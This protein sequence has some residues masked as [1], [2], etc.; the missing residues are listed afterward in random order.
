[1][2]RRKDKYVNVHIYMYARLDRQ[3]PGSVYPYIFLLW[4]GECAACAPAPLDLF[5]FRGNYHEQAEVEELFQEPIL[6]SD[7]VPSLRFEA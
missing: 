2:Y 5:E 4:Q 6:W 7:E 3:T 1:M